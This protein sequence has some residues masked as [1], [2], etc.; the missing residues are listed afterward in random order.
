MKPIKAFGSRFTGHDK[1]VDLNS[2]QIVNELHRVL[3]SS[4]RVK[5]SQQQPIVVF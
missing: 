2:Q 3:D 4:F 1:G 5:D